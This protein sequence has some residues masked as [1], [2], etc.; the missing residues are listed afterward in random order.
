MTFA[1]AS[2]D[3][4]GACAGCSEVD[5]VLGKDSVSLGLELVDVDLVGSSCPA[6]TQ[7][8]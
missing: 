3:K 2:R 8:R 6:E 1:L 7:V 4:A 5:V